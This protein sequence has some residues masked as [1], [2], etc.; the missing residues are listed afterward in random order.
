MKWIVDRDLP[1]HKIEQTWT[2][3]VVSM[4][5]F[6]A[7]ILTK[8]MKRVTQ[9]V[10]T[11]IADDLPDKIALVFYGLTH[12]SVH[13]LA[14]FEVYAK[15]KQKKVVLLAVA[16]PIDEKSYTADEHITF[17]QETLDIYG[18]TLENECSFVG[19]NCETNQ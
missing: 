11:Y 7:E 10:E 17:I 14:I 12:F 8:Y 16:P 1:L 9:L 4:Q 13:Y 6:S 5:S 2:R 3:K 15:D 18:K 19:D